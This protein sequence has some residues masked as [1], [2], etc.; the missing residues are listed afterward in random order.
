MIS[1]FMFP[2]SPVA[3][4]VHKLVLTVSIAIIIASFFPINTIMLM[5]GLLMLAVALVQEI[6]ISR[7]KKEY[8]IWY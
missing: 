4:I 3:T 6:R 2:E 7:A 5:I 8:N 1:Y